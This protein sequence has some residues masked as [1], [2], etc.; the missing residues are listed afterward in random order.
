MNLLFVGSG[1]G[2]WIMRGHQLGAALGAR[3]T[4]DPR[5]DDWTW[6][7]L[8]I[9]VKRH[10]AKFA[11]DAKAAG[12]AIVWDALDCWRQPADNSRTQ[13]A[14]ALDLAA[15]IAAITPWHV[16][17]ATQAQA[18]A[19]SG[20]YLPHHSW[21]GLEPTR[22]RREIQTVAYQGNVAYLGAWHGHLQRLCSARGWAFVVNPADLRDAD[23]IVALRE[24]PWDG[25]ACREW[26]SGVKLVNAMAAGRPVL[27]QQTAA[28]REIEP[29]GSAIETVGDLEAAFDAWRSLGSR[30]AAA[31]LCVDQ[32]KAYTVAAVAD[33][34]RSILERVTTCTTR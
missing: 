28:F 33:Q 6:A 22:P 25:W 21:S 14:A 24:G 23:L 8:V 13:T 20:S 26:K 31:D 1:Q 4:S 17:G 19:A 2:S 7:D 9:L 34:Y 10:G 16:I 5:R 32:A 3:V 27:T 29:P 12:V 18:D 30:V 11:A 15:Q